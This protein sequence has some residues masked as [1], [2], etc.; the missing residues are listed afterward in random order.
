MPSL[1]NTLPIGE[2]PSRSEN[3]KGGPRDTTRTA[4]KKQDLLSAERS[5][6]GPPPLKQPSGSLELPERASGAHTLL[7][8]LAANILLRLEQRIDR[9]FLGPLG[10]F[11]LEVQGLSGELLG[12]VDVPRCGLLGARGIEALLGY[13]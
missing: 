13:A 12:S 3:E 6:V 10:R 2:A 8:Q 1:M 9:G 7:N 4:C 11:D 5:H